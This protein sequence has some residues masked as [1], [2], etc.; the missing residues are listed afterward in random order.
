MENLPFWF[1]RSA[2]ASVPIGVRGLEITRWAILP[3]ATFGEPDVDYHLYAGD[4][5]IG[6]ITHLDRLA[7]ERDDGV[8]VWVFRIN[9]T[10]TFVG[11][12]SRR[13]KEQRHAVDP[14]ALWARL[15]GAPPGE[16]KA[17][18]RPFGSS[19]RARPPGRPTRFETT[20]P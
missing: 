7:F 12:S 15:A 19:R 17:A 14:E 11:W 8:V 9:E 10:Q 18:L 3:G 4:V 1:A 5:H 16:R 2:S 6:V 20:R 13:D